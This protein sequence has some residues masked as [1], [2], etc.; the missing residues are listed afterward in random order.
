[1][2]YADVGEPEWAIDY[3]QR[4][5]Q[6]SGE[7]ESHLRKAYALL[8]YCHMQCGRREAAMQT[9]R[10]GL[11]LFPGDEELR[12]RQAILLHEEGR[13]AEAVEAYRSVLEGPAERH[14][15]SMDRAMR[16][17]KGRQNLALVYADLG[18]W[19]EAE[20]QWR[21]VVAE[22]P[23]YR[24]GWR[25]LGEVLLQQGKLNDGEALAE[26]FLGDDR[27][28]A[29]GRLLQGQL[30]IARGDFEQARR[31]LRQAV[32]ESSND[33]AALQALCRFLFERG[34]PEE[35]AEALQ[36]LIRRDPGDAAAYHNLGTTYT[37]MCRPAA[38]VAAYRRSL[39]LRPNNPRTL[40]SLGY[41][42]AET[43]EVEAALDAWQQVLRLAPGQAEAEEAQQAIRRAR[44]RKR[45]AP[46][47]I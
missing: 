11:R 25:G 28:R 9:C 35:A 7:G 29:E 45:P 21:Q 36:E 20:A 39:A 41:A 44:E 4:S 19:A 27:L 32:A 34:E 38:A 43:E 17:F 37:R 23:H 42:L 13:L 18:E 16:G 6:W 31:L 3:L 33:L 40:L 15:S 26:Q 1:M 12:F 14:F 10:H 8:T 5:I 46:C 22:A 24:Q 2:T 47:P 30:A